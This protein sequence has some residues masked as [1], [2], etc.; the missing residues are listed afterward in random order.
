MKVYV[1]KSGHL[2]LTR[3]GALTNR[4]ADALRTA[5]RV[6]GLRPV[7]VN[8]QDTQNRADVSPDDY[9]DLDS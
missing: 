5:I 4:Q 7:T 6:D 8:M 1:L 9:E 2:Y 3:E